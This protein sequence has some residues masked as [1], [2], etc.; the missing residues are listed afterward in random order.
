[1]QIT[2]LSSLLP[3]ALCS[4]ATRAQSSTTT[5]YTFTQTITSGSVATPTKFEMV[6]AALASESEVDAPEVNG[7]YAGYD[8]TWSNPD[9]SVAK[10]F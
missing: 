2:K 8:P 6:Q 4:V 5:I 9:Y 7:L 3:L 1:M 10:V